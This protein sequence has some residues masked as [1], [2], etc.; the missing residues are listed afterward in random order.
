[1]IF[2]GPRLLVRPAGAW[3]KTV[4]VEA[5]PTAA[6]RKAHAR[7]LAKRLGLSDLLDFRAQ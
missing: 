1:M 3:S 5:A 6:E 2:N 4:R 7:T